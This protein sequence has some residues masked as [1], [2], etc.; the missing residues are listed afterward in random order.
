MTTAAKSNLYDSLIKWKKNSPKPQQHKDCIVLF[1][2]PCVHFNIAAI[3]FSGTVHT[4]LN[5][6]N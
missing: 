4:N 3:I 5:N 6:Y 1:I 2:L